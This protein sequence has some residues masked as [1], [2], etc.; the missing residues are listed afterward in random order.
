MIKVYT[1]QKKPAYMEQN[2]ENV[3]R[4]LLFILILTYD[5]C[6]ESQKSGYSKKKMF[7]IKG[8]K[9]TYNLLMVSIFFK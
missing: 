2:E 3:K 1:G 9:S 8:Y 5:L 6:A 7:V 4:F